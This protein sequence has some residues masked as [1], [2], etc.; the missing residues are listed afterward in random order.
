[1]SNDENIRRELVTT[2]LAENFLVALEMAITHAEKIGLGDS[3]LCQGWREIER[4]LKRAEHINVKPFTQPLPEAD[5]DKPAAVVVRLISSRVEENAP[6]FAA[7]AP[8]N[9]IP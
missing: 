8:S 9:T 7:G 1:M 2:I 4:A 6:G 3:G 5:M